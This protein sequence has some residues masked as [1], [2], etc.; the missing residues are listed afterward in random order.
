MLQRAAAAGTE[1]STHRLLARR[2]F[3]SDVV[4]APATIGLTRNLDL[5]AGQRVRK[6]GHLAI[7]VSAPVPLVSQM[8]DYDRMPISHHQRCALPP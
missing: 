5:L 1:M 6:I 8:A 7:D 2:T 3:N 4:N